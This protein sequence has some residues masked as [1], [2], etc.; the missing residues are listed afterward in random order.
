[1]SR[2][3]EVVQLPTF[4]S[5]IT[6]IFHFWAKEFFFHHSF[7]VSC[8]FIKDNNNKL[9]TFQTGK[10]HEIFQ[11]FLNKIRSQFQ[12]FSP[13]RRGPGGGL[14]GLYSIECPRIGGKKTISLKRFFSPT[15]APAGPPQNLIY[16]LTLARGPSIKAHKAENTTEKKKNLTVMTVIFMNRENKT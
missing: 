14:G 11:Y 6:V 3:C 9:S 16:P 1:M 10:I 5:S 2:L 12:N 13:R 15:R 8:L 7:Q 4:Q